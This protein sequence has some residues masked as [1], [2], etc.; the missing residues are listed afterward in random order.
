[1]NTLDRDLA[2]ILDL[3]LKFEHGETLSMD[4]FDA[5]EHFE[6]LGYWLDSTLPLPFEDITDDGEPYDTLASFTDDG[7]PEAV[8]VYYLR[9]GQP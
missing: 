5:L 6:Q 1:M 4:E 9:R 3:L 2:G 8:V 7:N